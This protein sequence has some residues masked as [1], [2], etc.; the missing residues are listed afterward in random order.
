MAQSCKCDLQNDWM[1]VEM[2][3][4]GPIAVEESDIVMEKEIGMNLAA[5]ESVQAVRKK[6]ETNLDSDMKTY[7]ISRPP[8][9][10]LLDKLLKMVAPRKPNGVLVILPNCQASERSAIHASEPSAI[11]DVSSKKIE[12]NTD[13]RGLAT[14]N[15]QEKLALQSGPDLVRRAKEL[16]LKAGIK[17]TTVM[18]DRKRG[19]LEPGDVYRDIPMCQ[20]SVQSKRDGAYHYNLGRVLSPLKQEGVLILASGIAT[21]NNNGLSDSET[22]RSPDIKSTM[23]FDNWL[24]YCLIA[25]RFEDIIRFERRSP[26]NARKIH[27]FIQRFYPLLVALG[28]AGEGAIAKR[29]ENGWVFG[30]DA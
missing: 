21:V 8:T 18:E 1:L 17:A 14:E 12:T 11:H 20:L 3:E 28:A 6:E 5:G 30:S 19:V 27:P 25:N 29:V 10:E 7:Y 13:F 16:L 24:S 15:H 22:N 2:A 9:K 4:S 26:S 23:A